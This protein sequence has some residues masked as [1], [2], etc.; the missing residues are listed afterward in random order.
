MLTIEKLELIF[1]DFPVPAL[2]LAPDEGVKILKAN[3]AYLDLV[4]LRPEELCGRPLFEVFPDD[5]VENPESVVKRSNR[6][7]REAVSTKEPKSPG[8]IAYPLTD[9]FNGSP[10]LRFFMPEFVPVVNESGEVSYIFHFTHEV[11]GQIAESPPL[12]HPIITSFE[13]I[14]ET[15]QNAFLL[16]TG[17]GQVLLANKAACM[18]FGYSKAEFGR[19]K[20]HE[21]LDYNDERL[22][23]LLEQREKSGAAKGEITGIKRNGQRFP[24]EY[25]TSQFVDANGE[26][27]CCTE[28]VDLSKWKEEEAK[29]SRSE[30]NLKTIFNST[31]GGFVLV[32]KNLNILA[33]NNRANEFIQLNSNNETSDFRIGS[34]IL[35]YIAQ[36][37]LT[38]FKGIIQQALQGEVI[39]YTRTYH[40][41]GGNYWYDFSI[42]PVWEGASVTGLCISGRDITAQKQAEQEVI[43]NEQ[44]FRRL[45]ENNTDAI[46]ILSADFKVMYVSPAGKHITGYT[47]EDARQLGSLGTIHEE[48][49]P[50][51]MRIMAEVMKSPGKPVKASPLRMQ[52][53]DGSW[54]WVEATITNM[55][56]DPAIGGII[57]N[58][59][60]VTERIRSA[61]RLV[62]AR[63]A[64]ELSEIKYRKIFNQSPLPKWIY[65]LE[66]F[67]ILEVNEA[68]VR[69]YGYSRE[70][71]L[72]MTILDIRP[73]ED[74]LNVEKMVRDLH[75]SNPSTTN[76][77]RHLKKDGEIILVDIY[78]HP[79]EFNDR[80]AR[81]VVCRDVTER[82]AYLNAVEAQNKQLR[83]IAWFQSHI[84]RAP[85]AR[86]LGL[87]NLLSMEPTEANLKEILPMLVESAED[88]DKIVQDIVTKTNTI[89]G[90]L[91]E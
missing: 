23:A 35:E 66:T 27:R 2:I 89:Y 65:D 50:A 45:V 58:F 87:V 34:S 47:E 57:D 21:L 75:G 14:L 5:E 3:R 71:F 28:L 22:H 82:L 36:D 53:K 42:N 8:A 37:R 12:K 86:I 31:P 38:D 70:E 61:R 48:D 32:D 16:T 17:D 20:R 54:R 15:A 30:L 33:C 85:L 1:P 84:V 41:N 67:H 10:T 78:S 62:D 11:K 88:L 6:T 90:D 56:H 26:K 44:R 55:L 59:W 73:E 43:N 77:W 18:L 60:D 80:N 68:A 63:H 13:S 24:C 7:I 74:R 4:G 51:A 69:H 91:C 40:S 76:Y 52:H 9:V 29:I 25:S 79:I 64:A 49:L 39:T 81:M 46:A 83:D 72:S 19:A